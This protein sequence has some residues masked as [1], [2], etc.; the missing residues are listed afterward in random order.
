[1]TPAGRATAVMP[2]GRPTAVPPVATVVP[3]IRPIGAPHRGRPALAA[4]SVE[5][6]V[7]LSRR[8][9]NR[10]VRGARVQRIVRSQPALHVV[11]P[12]PV[13]L[14]IANPLAV[15]RRARPETTGGSLAAAPPAPAA[16]PAGPGPV[17]PNARLVPQTDEAGA[18]ATHRTG[19]LPTGPL[20][21]G[22]A[23]QPGP[24]VRTLRVARN[25]GSVVTSGS[26]RVPARMTGAARVVP[27]PRAA[28]TGPVMTD[29][30][31]TANV[32][33]AGPPAAKAMLV[34]PVAGIT[35]A[36]IARIGQALR[37]MREPVNRLLEADAVIG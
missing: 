21:T 22:A 12:R 23:G 17:A 16:R 28:A 19:P 5:T 15:T 13:V 9:P 36:R 32:P 25:R 37:D 7:V 27:V 30:V 26:P 29:R 31:G 18:A 8:V 34:A 24:R 2:A 10:I 1:M 4:R 20:L 6:Y 11:D 35:E 3:A 14:M 33:L